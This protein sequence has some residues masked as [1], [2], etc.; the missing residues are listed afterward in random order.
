MWE[1]IMIEEY[2]F[3]YS[4]DEK[5]PVGGVRFSGSNL[6]SA[7]AAA[8][9]VC[10]LFFQQLVFADVAI[11]QDNLV[12]YAIAAAKDA[13]KKV[14]KAFEKQNNVSVDANY[15]GCFAT[16]SQQLKAGN[17][18]D[19]FIP[20]SMDIAEVMLR[21][22]MAI[23][24]VPFAVNRTC[25]V[26]PKGSGVVR[27]FMDITRPGVRLAFGNFKVT[28]IGK[29]SVEI[30]KKAGIYRKIR[31]NITTQALC[32]DMM[33]TYVEQGNVDAALVWEK[34]ARNSGKVDV[35]AIPDEF[36]VNETIPICLLA[37]SSRPE[38]QKDYEKFFLSRGMEIFRE[39]GYDLLESGEKGGPT[40]TT[41]ESFR[42]AS[43]SGK[44][45]TAE[46]LSPGD[47]VLTAESAPVTE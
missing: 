8:L 47:K 5:L 27:E 40:G 21:D 3:K 38:L 16:V 12:V 13:V 30:L 9:L 7:G 34:D 17:Q 31:R 26:I 41:S 20:G 4:E 24:A 15:V 44:V 10:S 14:N 11:A 2:N 29:Y 46:S 37:G 1:E 25:L 45:L 33:M 23:S 35:V 18:V 32:I 19:V 36:S 42:T 6:F 28:P 43:I 22:R 39:G